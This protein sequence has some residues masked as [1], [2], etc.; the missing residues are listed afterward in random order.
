MDLSRN[1]ADLFRICLWLPIMKLG[2]V[3]DSLCFGQREFGDDSAGHM[4][5]LLMCDTTFKV[6]E[7]MI[8]CASFLFDKS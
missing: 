5:R 4:N 3:Q 7:S 2:F 8:S 1:F 6:L